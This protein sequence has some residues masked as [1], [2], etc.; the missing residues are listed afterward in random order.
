[1]QEC[2]KAQCV[3]E[4]GSRPP[5]KVWVECE[6]HGIDNCE[7]PILAENSTKVLRNVKLIDPDGL[8]KG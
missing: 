1:M 3:M 5:N 7:P 6:I 4:I 8:L 2:S